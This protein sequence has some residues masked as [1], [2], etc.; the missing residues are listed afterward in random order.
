MRILYISKADSQDF[1]CDMMFHG[2]RSLCGPDVVDDNRITFMYSDYPVELL[3]S[4]CF[5]TIYGLL[6]PIAVDRTDIPRKIAT[7]YFDLIVYGSIHRCL[8]YF[9][10][11]MEAYPRDRVLMLDGEDDHRYSPHCRDGI[12]FKRELN[13]SDPEI[14]PIGFS[15]PREKIVHDIPPK[16]RVFAPLIPGDHST[17]IYYAS[18]TRLETRIAAEASYYRQYSESYFGR[19][20]KKGGWDCCRHYE[21]M[22][23]GALPYFEDLEHCPERTLHFFPKQELLAARRMADSWGDHQH[24]PYEGLLLAVRT[25]LRERLTTEAMAKYMVEAAR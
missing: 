1:L 13:V 23:S 7:R 3:N 9:T 11:V 18:D 20:R 4:K 22:L 17:Y 21:I 6:D 25:A 15:I 14:L 2:L 12:Y 5:F 19:T 8:D 16:T 24:L 10:E